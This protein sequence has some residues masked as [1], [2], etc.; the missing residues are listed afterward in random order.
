M[1][2]ECEFCGEHALDCTCEG[3]YRESYQ[4]VNQYW[5]KAVIDM[6]FTHLNAKL[7]PLNEFEGFDPPAEKL[8]RR[9]ID[10]RGREEHEAM[11]KDEEKMLSLGLDP[12]YERIVYLKRWEGWLNENKD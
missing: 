2:G 6:K 4:H 8:K 7:K 12:V 9:W 11:L 1:S 3:D 10:V 5:K